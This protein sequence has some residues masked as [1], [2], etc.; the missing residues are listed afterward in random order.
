MKLTLE[1]IE[2]V[3]LE[4][5]EAL[6]Y[7]KEARH[8]AKKVY[9]NDVEVSIYLKYAYEHVQRATKVLEMQG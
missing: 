7:A 9:G 1:E 6:T 8:I 5:A 2:I 4:L 3:L